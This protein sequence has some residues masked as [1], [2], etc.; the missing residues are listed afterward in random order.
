MNEIRIVNIEPQYASG[1][2]ALQRVVF[3]N[4]PPHELFKEQDFYDIADIF[5]EG[6]FVGLD[7][8]RVVALGSGL[9]LDF[10]WDDYQHT[11]EEIVTGE[12]CYARHNPDAPYYYGTDISVHPEYRRRGIGKRLYELRKAV[13]KDF[14][15][16]GIVAG[17]LL[18]GYH[19]Y[20]DELTPME[21]IDRVVA[22]ELYDPTLSFQLANGFEVRGFLK[23]YFPHPS[24]GDYASLIFWPNPDYDPNK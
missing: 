21:Y 11:L 12:R 2:Q 22:G 10:D 9:F 20:E 19:Q 14:N 7:G 1:L 18:P 6:S 15:K 4:T 13:V 5:P 24:S 17:G 3:P 23:H 16:Q 8:D